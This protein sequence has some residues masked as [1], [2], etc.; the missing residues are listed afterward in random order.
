MHVR[1]PE[2]DCLFPADRLAMHHPLLHVRQCVVIDGAGEAAENHRQRNPACVDDASHGPRQ[3]VVIRDFDP[4]EKNVGHLQRAHAKRALRGLDA[5]TRRFCLDDEAPHA[6][7]RLRRH[8]QPIAARRER[9]ER[10]GTFDPPAVPGP[11]GA[12]RAS[13]SAKPARIARDDCGEDGRVR[14]EG[15]KMP[16]ALGFR[17]LHCDGSGETQRPGEHDSQRRVAVSDFIERNRVQHRGLV[18]RLG[19]RGGLRQSE[20]PGA[21]QQ[22]FRKF[23]GLVGGAGGRA[24]LVRGE[25][26]SRGL[27]EDLLFRKRKRDHGAPISTVR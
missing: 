4:V 27:N 14:L 20:F 15:G 11:L 24:S 19:S 6:L 25:L 23:A 10:L 8:Q 17:S 21:A 13:S 1:E 7:V 22:H 3:E 12:R 26:L 16:L 18:D 5:K 9:N 2:G